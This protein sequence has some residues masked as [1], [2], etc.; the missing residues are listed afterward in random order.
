MQHE[1]PQQQYIPEDVPFASRR[2][3]TVDVPVDSRGYTDVYINDTT[4]L[5]VNLPESGNVERLEAAIP[6]VTK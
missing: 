5:T 3:L 2:E 4:G 6:L 1:I